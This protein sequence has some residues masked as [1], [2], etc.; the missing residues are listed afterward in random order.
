MAANI[1]ASPQAIDKMLR[2]MAISTAGD[3]AYRIHT[4]GKKADGSQIG[5][6]SAGYMKVRTGKFST[7]QTYRS[8]KRKGETKPTG[9]FTRGKNK[10]QKRPS[11]NRTDST[12]VVFSLTR[13]MENDFSLKETKEPIRTVNGYGVGFKNPI[14]TKKYQWLSEKNPNVY[15]LSVSEKKKVHK[16]AEEFIKNLF[17]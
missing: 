2:T 1:K 11:Y 16:I 14:N 4:E 6:Y 3:M 12:K 8:G 15:E 5:T 17:K 7:N 9:V 13:Q 10:G